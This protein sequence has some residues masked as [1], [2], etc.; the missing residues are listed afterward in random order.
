MR[1][2]NDRTA[3]SLLLERGPLTRTRLGELTGLSK[4][5]ASQVVTRLERAGL[6][7]PVG[8]ESAP[9]GP[10]AA[11]YGVRTDREH[12]VAVDV[13]PHRVTS[14]LVDA[15]GDEHPVAEVAL[16]RAAA[17]RSA[18]E[19]IRAALAAACAAADVDPATV[20]EVVVGLQGAVDP[21][22]DDLTF[23]GLLPGWPRR[24]TRACLEDGLGLRVR[25]DN[26]ANLAAVAERAA[27]AGSGADGFALLWMG[28]GLGVAVD[29]R[30]TLHRGAGGG[31]GE[32]G[33]LS[34]PRE[35]V[36]LDPAAV[37]MQDLLGGTGVARV[38]RAHGARGRTLEAVLASL[39][40]LPSRRDALRDLARRIALG[41]VPVLAVLDPPLVV[42]GG[43]TGAA[44][45][46]ELAEEVRAQVRRVSRWAPQVVATAVPDHPVIRGARALAVA[47]LRA[48]LLARVV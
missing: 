47:D 22:T 15:A 48:R 46:E 35:A 28:E 13:Q 31:A 33:Y 29:L 45:G 39:A 43:P 3:L 7:A 16:A 40:T 24:S 2:L 30:G 26:D 10:Q 12:V 21:R 5:T 8:A 18:V 19:D 32:I 9:R 38:V 23:T 37:D 44:G 1:S 36:E 6:I 42:L 25:I 34:V 4:P 14:T 27:G 20:V 41:V 11:T 17:D